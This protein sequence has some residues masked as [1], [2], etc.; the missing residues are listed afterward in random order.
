MQASAASSPAYLD[1]DSIQLFE[2]PV[3]VEE[4]SVHGIHANGRSLQEHH[5]SFA[6]AFERIV[7]HDGVANSVG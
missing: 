3:V 2:L 4:D 7:R 6:A 5:Y 1:K